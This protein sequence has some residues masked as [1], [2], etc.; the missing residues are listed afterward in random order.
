M[1]AR[2]EIC[3][4]CTLGGRIFP[5]Y[6]PSFSRRRFFTIAG[7]GIVGFTLADVLAPPRKLEAAT[8]PAVKGTARNCIFVFMA[9][10]PSHSD[11]W[12]LKEGA[13][14][15]AAFAPASFGGNVRFAQGLMPKIAEHLDRLV[16]VRSALSWAAVHS[17]AQVWAQQSRNPA[18]VLGDIAPNIG[19]VVSLEMTPQRKPG[20]VLPG[21]V[22]LASGPAKGSGYLPARYAPFVAT[23]LSA[24]GLATIRPN[25]GQPVFDE[26]FATLQMLDTDRTGAPLGDAP[27]DMND[28][29]GQARA[30]VDSPSVNAY[31][32]WSTADY[33]RYG[34]TGFGGAA[35]VAKQLLA[36]NQGTRYIQLTMGGWDNHANIYSPNA[37]LFSQMKTFDPAIGALLGDLAATPGATAGRSLLDETL[38]VMFGEFG[39]TVGPP[40]GQGG[41]DHFLRMS[42]AMAGGGT[43]GGRAIGVTDATA[44]KVL[45]Y[46]WSGN[47]DIRIEDLTCTLYSALGIDY[48]TVRHDDPLGRGYEYVPFAKDGVYRPVDEVF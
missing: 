13:W 3:E 29:Y 24:T 33:A 31:F 23:G 8:A 34:S 37:G 42:V 19:S 7:T 35:L 40:N 45:D 25:G 26:R 1:S 27:A 36:A 5:V 12:D 32:G 48:T 2:K 20:D 21:F 9:G 4:A 43:T 47:R 44:N 16:F 38:V 39:R 41:R 17:L 15:P 11:L 14:T 28:F 46:G 6:G 30:L 18:G 22:G 10:G